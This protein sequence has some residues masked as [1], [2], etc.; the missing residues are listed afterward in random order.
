M[1]PTANGPAG[2]LGSQAT[3][4]W[5]AIYLNKTTA[6]L[7][8]FVRGVDLTT[9]DTYAMQSLCAYETVALGFSAFCGL[10]TEQEWKGYEYS[11]GRVSRCHLYVSNIDI[12]YCRLGILVLRRS[13]NPEQCSTRHWIRSGALVATHT[14]KTDRVQH[15]CQRHCCQQRDDIPARSADICRRYA[16]YCN[17]I[18]YVVLIR[19]LF[20]S[21]TRYIMMWGSCR[22]NEFHEY[23]RKWALATRSHSWKTGVFLRNLM[24]SAADTVLCT[25][26]PRAT[27]CAFRIKSRRTDSFLSGVSR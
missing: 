6:R 8:R 9:T 21:L 16:R 4:A 7:Q 15:H 5:T 20:L 14:T 27:Y 25:D 2:Q 22:R 12:L 18:K 13:R 11:L 3:A 23:G 24:Y 26:V 1:C 10:F 17:L 19:N